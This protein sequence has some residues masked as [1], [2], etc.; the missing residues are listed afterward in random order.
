MRSEMTT[1]WEILEIGKPENNRNSNFIMTCLRF[2]YDGFLEIAS[3]AI[4]GA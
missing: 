3:Y 1:I 2:Q 4:L